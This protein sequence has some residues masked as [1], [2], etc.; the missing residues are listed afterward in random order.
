MHYPP[1]KQFVINPN[2]QFATETIYFLV[3]FILLNVF[4]F[5]MCWT[6]TYVVDPNNNTDDNENEGGQEAT[7][8]VQS[9]RLPSSRQVIIL[10]DNKIAYATRD[11]GSSWGGST[12]NENYLSQYNSGGQSGTIIPLYHA[13]SIE[14]VSIGNE[15][16]RSFEISERWNGSLRGSRQRRQNLNQEDAQQ[17]NNEEETQAFRSFRH[18]AGGRVYSENFNSID[19]EQGG[20]SQPQP[21]VQGARYKSS[22]F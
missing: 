16:T 1:V 7:L 20:E 15:S 8:Q 9:L 10:P 11:D 5:Y 13:Q 3:G 14:L 12:R 19:E 17:N 2:N 6:R 22:L 18:N 4:C 21:L